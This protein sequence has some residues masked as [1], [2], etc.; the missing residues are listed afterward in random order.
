[1]Y[2]RLSRGFLLAEAT[3]KTATLKTATFFMLSLATAWPAMTLAGTHSPTSRLHEI[4]DPDTRAW[5]QATQALSDDAMEGRDTGSP[6]HDRAAALV[7][8]RFAEAGLRPAGDDGSWFQRFRLNDLRVTPKGSR[9]AVGK[10][11]LRLLYDI[12]LRP[13]AG[14]PTRLD[15]PMVF[16]GYCAADALGDVRGKVVL[17]YGWRRAGLTTSVQRS[18]AVEAAGGVGLITLADPGFTLEPTRWPAAYARTMTPV[19]APASAAGRMLVATLNPQALAAVIAGTGQDAKQ[20]LALGSAG[21]PLPRFDLSGRFEAQLHLE[22]RVVTSANVL[23]V[24]PGTDPKLRDQYLVLSAHLDGYGHGEPVDGDGLYNGTLDDAAYVALLERLATRRHGK[25]Y[26]RPVLFAAFTGEEKGLLGSRYFV[27]HPTVPR[28]AI[29]ANINLDQL[30]PIFPLTRLTV[31]ALDDST[32]GDTVRKVAARDDIV[33]QLDPE[34]E[35]NLLRR[36]DHWS[37]VQAG[38]PATG[39]V[40]GYRPGTDAEKRYRHW[41]DVQYHRPQDDLTQPMNWPAAGKFNRF[42]YHLVAAVADADAAP[43]WKPGSPLAPRAGTRA[44]P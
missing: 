4:S 18:G 15:A 12:T 36:A 21:K 2:S 29:A 3:L 37:F 33:V 17:C 9:I 11:P 13:S 22:Q 8:K 44:S 39:F 32:L 40:F 34:P 42:F 28:R 6:G 43:Q 24:L 25:G 41:Y 10:T 23:G 26:R 7:A 38:I 19:D 5:W 1:L 20:I 35:R 27:A 14:M 31:H 16:A 30:R